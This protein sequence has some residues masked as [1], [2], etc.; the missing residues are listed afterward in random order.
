MTVKILTNHMVLTV[1]NPMFERP[2]NNPF[3]TIKTWDFDRSKSCNFDRSKSHVLV[4]KKHPIFD[5]QNHTF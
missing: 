1:Q 4:V 3:L 2:K 5:H